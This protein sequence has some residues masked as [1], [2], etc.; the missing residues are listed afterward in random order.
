MAGLCSNF[1]LFQFEEKKKN[2]S[3]VYISDLQF[4]LV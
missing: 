3:G 1:E 4:D 2:I